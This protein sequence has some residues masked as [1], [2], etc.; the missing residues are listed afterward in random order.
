[1]LKKQN[2]QVRV[3]LSWKNEEFT[4]LFLF[5]LHSFRPVRFLLNPKSVSEWGGRGCFTATLR[6]LPPQHPQPIHC[7]EPSAEATD[8]AKVSNKTLD[9]ESADKRTLCGYNLWLFFE[10]TSQTLLLPVKVGGGL[11]H[12]KPLQR[13]ICHFNDLFN[14]SMLARNTADLTA[15]NSG[16]KKVNTPI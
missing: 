9:I 13:H 1:M 3:N 16:L 6:T 5:F 14:C 2:K 4:L 15:P 11:H 10:V 12:R 8:N 7:Q